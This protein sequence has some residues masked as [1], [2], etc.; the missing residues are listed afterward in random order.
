VTALAI[1]GSLPPSTPACLAVIDRIT[2]RIK[3]APQTPIATYHVLH[4]GVYSR[5]ICI[6]AEVGLTSALIKIPTTLVICGHASVMFGDGE[7]AVVCGYQVL[8]ASAGRRQAYIA[9]APT[10]ITMSFRTQAKS[11]EEAEREFTDEADLLMS[12]SGENTVLITG[13]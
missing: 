11:V 9:H 13:D 5:T 7:E 10:H 2:E 12:R 3:A 8:A 4:A 6:P 1:P